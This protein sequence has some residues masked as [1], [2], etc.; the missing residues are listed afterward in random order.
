MQRGIFTFFWTSD[1]AGYRCC[2]TF[3]VW[4][5]LGFMTLHILYLLPSKKKLG[6]DYTS[7]TYIVKKNLRWRGFSG[8]WSVKDTTLQTTLQV[9]LVNEKKGKHQHTLKN[10]FTMF[11]QSKPSL[12]CRFSNC[13]QDSHKT[14]SIVFFQSRSSRHT[15][16]KRSKYQFDFR[17]IKCDR[18]ISKLKSLRNHTAYFSWKWL[19]MKYFLE[20]TRTWLFGCT[21]FTFECE[22]AIQ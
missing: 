16:V 8:V 17:A 5:F 19:K 2:Y 3:T 18:K 7:P 12:C 9:T 15:N 14:I 13:G 22:T 21:G 11:L 6:Y 4:T 10:D 20:A 1:W